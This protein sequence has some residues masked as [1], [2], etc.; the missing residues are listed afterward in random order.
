MCLM[1]VLLKVVFCKAFF[2][3]LLV[4]FCFSDFSGAC[5]SLTQRPFKGY[6]LF[7]VSL[8]QIQVDANVCNSLEQLALGSIRSLPRLNSANVV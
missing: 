6:V 5:L 4:L 2:K 3:G 8:K 1:L 7:V